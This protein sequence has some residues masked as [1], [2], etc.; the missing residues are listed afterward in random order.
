MDLKVEVTQQNIKQGL[1][2]SYTHGA[3]S[4]AIGEAVRKTYKVDKVKVMICN[5]D[6]GFINDIYFDLPEQVKTFIKMS[7]EQKTVMPICFTLENFP[8][9]LF[10]RN[11]SRSR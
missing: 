11:P 2:K 1:V 7:D 3:V 9:D 4:L 10:S 5:L 6:F 8:D